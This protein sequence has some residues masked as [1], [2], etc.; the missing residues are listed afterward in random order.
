[1]SETVKPNPLSVEPVG[2]LILKFAVPSTIALIINALYNIVDQIFIGNIVGYLGNA[3]T[4]IIFPLTVFS[5]AIPS[6]LGEGC[7]AYFSLQ[8]GKG[9]REK[10]SRGICNTLLLI[11]VISISI[12]TLC[13]LFMTQLC[14]LFG[15][16]S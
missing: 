7:A 4:N 16:S 1:M 14:K 2:K 9:N 11:T 5:I 3:A 15:A 8:L 6:L 13:E 12:L 10:G